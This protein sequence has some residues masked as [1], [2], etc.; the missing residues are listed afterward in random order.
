[1]MRL[2]PDFQNVHVALD[3]VG[4]NTNSKSGCTISCGETQ[5]I[6]AS[7]LFAVTRELATLTTDYDTFDRRV[8]RGQLVRSPRRGESWRFHSARFPR[9]FDWNSDRSEIGEDCLSPPHLSFFSPLS[10]AKDGVERSKSKRKIFG[11]WRWK[12]CVKVWDL[13]RNWGFSAGHLP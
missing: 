5:I 11:S 7:L 13:W 9:P 2:R 1:M 10:R 12:V 4:P 6:Q 3:R 8:D